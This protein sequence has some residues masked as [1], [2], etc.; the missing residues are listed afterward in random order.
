MVNKDLNEAFEWYQ[1]AAGER[2]SVRHL[3]LGTVRKI[4]DA[5]FGTRTEA[6][7]LLYKYYREGDCPEG[8][9]QPTKAVYYLTKAA[10]QGDTDAQFELGRICMDGSCEQIKD[11]RKAKRWLE[12]ASANGDVKASQVSNQHCTRICDGGTQTV[13]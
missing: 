7:R 12:K 4:K 11:L 5:L 2:A 13:S 1:T 10:E 9:P 8:R 6:L 3:N